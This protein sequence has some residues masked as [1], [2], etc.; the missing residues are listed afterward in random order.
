MNTLIIILAL[1]GAFVLLTMTFVL[2]WAIIQ[3]ITE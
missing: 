1:F 3:E 2:I